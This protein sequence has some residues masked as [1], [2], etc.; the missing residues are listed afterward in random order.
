MFHLQGKHRGDPPP[1]ETMK[2]S[3]DKDGGHLGTAKYWEPPHPQYMCVLL[4][5]EAAAVATPAVATTIERLFGMLMTVRPYAHPDP[6][7]NAHMIIKA[8]IAGNGTK[9]KESTSD[10]AQPQRPAAE[11]Q[12]QVGNVLDARGASSAGEDHNDRKPNS[13]IPH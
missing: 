5:T 3:A 6:T 13:S 8:S 10:F 12:R 7:K 1:E 4:R 9:A 11:T 2:F